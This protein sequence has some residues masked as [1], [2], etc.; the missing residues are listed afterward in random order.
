M[1][2]RPISFASLP[3]AWSRARTHRHSNANSLNI[4]V[5]CFRF[6][7]RPTFANRLFSNFSVFHFPQCENQKKWAEN[8]FFSSVLWVLPE[9]VTRMK[10]K[11]ENSHVTSQL[12]LCGAQVVVWK[13]LD[14]SVRW[15]QLHLSDLWAAIEW[16]LIYPRSFVH[17]FVRAHK[18]LL[19]AASSATASSVGAD[20]NQYNKTLNHKSHISIQL[21]A[22]AVTT[23]ATLAISDLRLH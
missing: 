3:I 2:L 17:S 20:E 19:L 22:R 11:D 8:I 5:S 4:S 13:V 16:K 15:Q 6:H 18:V 23:L 14:F 21:T 12:I 7:R 10:S 1:W 9:C